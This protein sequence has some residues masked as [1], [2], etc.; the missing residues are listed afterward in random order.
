MRR[1]RLRS[2]TQLRR[3][4]MGQKT[5]MN[6][7]LYSMSE[8]FFLDVVEQMYNVKIDRQYNLKNRYYDGRFGEHLL[9]IDGAHWHTKLKDRKRDYL[10]DKLAEQ[11]GFKI[12]R[13]RLNKVRDVPMAIAQHK[14]L[15]DEIFYGNSSQKSK[16]P[17]SAQ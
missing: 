16:I 4:G 1:R 7:G 10:K 3:K 8:K 9:E 13:I 2:S 17:S 15:L 5:Y 12:H 11:F 6:G 14:S